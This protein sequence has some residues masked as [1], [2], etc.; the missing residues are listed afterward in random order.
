MTLSVAEIERFRIDKIFSQYCKQR[1]PPHDRDH[2]KKIY[3]IKGNKVILI[4]SRNFYYD[5]AKWTE[6]PIACFE[7]N[8]TTNSW[9]LHC[10]GKCSKGIP[11]SKDDLEK[12]LHELDKGSKVIFCGVGGI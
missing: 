6:V 8:V 4:E 10:F 2:V 5:P 11:V 9:S 3:Q 1:I 12:L 7:Y